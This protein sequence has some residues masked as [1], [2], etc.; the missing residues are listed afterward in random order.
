MLSAFVL[1]VSSFD[2]RVTLLA[3]PILVWYNRAS[4]HKFIVGSV[5]FI[6]AFN[7]PFF[8]YSDIGF[9][10]LEKRVKGDMVGAMYAYDWFPLVAVATLTIVEAVTLYAVKRGF[11]FHKQKEPV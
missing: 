6:A 10:F 5:G 1:A 3:L 2:P 11:S 8:F 7:L 9:T 4:L